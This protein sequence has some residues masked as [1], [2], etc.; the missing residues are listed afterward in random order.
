MQKLH[1][2]YLEKPARVRV[3]R[4]LRCYLD[5]QAHTFTSPASF[6][7]TGCRHINAIRLLAEYDLRGLYRDA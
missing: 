2:S 7:L 5:A 3:L 1:E 6:T 4:A